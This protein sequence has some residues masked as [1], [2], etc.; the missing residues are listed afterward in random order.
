MLRNVKINKYCVYMLSCLC[1]G[2]A[3]TDMHCAGK[4]QN[5][6]YVECIRPYYS[7]GEIRDKSALYDICAL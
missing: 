7:A 6:I 1:F 3:E 5:I 2:N 4:M